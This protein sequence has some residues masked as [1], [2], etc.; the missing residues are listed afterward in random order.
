MTRLT[1]EPF[2][3]GRGVRCSSRVGR[4]FEAHQRPVVGLL[5]RPTL[6]TSR[7]TPLKC[8][9]M[10]AGWIGFISAASASLT[11]RTE[12]LLTPRKVLP[13]LAKGMPQAQ[14]AKPSTRVPEQARGETPQAEFVLTS[15]TEILLNGKPCSYEEIPDHASIVRMDVA[16]D[17]KTVL[18]IHFRTQK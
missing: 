14:A 17:K 10:L 15:E 13:V 18:K 11:P 5:R 3:G 16:A 7:S 6:P 2:S 9:L 4:V 1:L 8:A 12:S